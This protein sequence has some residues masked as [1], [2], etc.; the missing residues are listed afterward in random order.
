MRIGILSNLHNTRYMN[1][2]QLI[3]Q[4]LRVSDIPPILVYIHP[5]DI[6]Y[7]QQHSILPNYITH[8]RL[9]SLILPGG[10]EPTY[11]PTSIVRISA[12]LLLRCIETYF[13]RLPVYG[14]CQGFQL[15]CMYFGSPLETIDGRRRIIDNVKYTYLQHPHKHYHT[16]TLWNRLRERKTLT[17]GNHPWFYFNH[18]YCIRKVNTKVLSPMGRTRNYISIVEHKTLPWFGTQFHPE[19]PLHRWNG[20]T[21]SGI[22]VATVFIKWFIEWIEWIKTNH[23][24]KSTQ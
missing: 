9:D 15:L 1:R 22:N 11:D 5:N 14:D 17:K 6:L 10:N 23:I 20:Y 8:L 13:P 16:R 24:V 4:L 2:T 7:K 12:F 18:G 3:K 21:H 19:Y